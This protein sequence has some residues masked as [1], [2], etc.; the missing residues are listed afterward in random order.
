MPNPGGF[1]N[2]MKSILVLG[3]AGYIGSV[4]INDLL[5]KKYKVT[6]IDNFMYEQSSLNHLLFDKNLNVENKDVRNIKNIKDFVKS[7]DCIFP[8]AAFVGAP[9][10]KK[11]PLG[12]ELINLKSIQDLLKILSKD[13]Y[14][15]M[16]TTN[17]AYGSGNSK[18]YCDEKS[19]LKPISKYA[20]DKVEVEKNI[21]NRRNSISLRLATVFGMSPRMRLDL[22]INDFVYKA[23]NDKYIVLFESHFKRNYIHVMDVSKAFL[24]CMKNFNKMKGQIYNVGLS[25]AN[26]SK[27]EICNLIK[28]YLPEFVILQ[29]NIKKDE[30]QRNYIVSNKKIENTGYKADY[31]IKDGI[32][33]LIKAFKYF[34]KKGYSNI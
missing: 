24:H 16:P 1:N 18:N 21:M 33:E 9:L 26:L 2:Y 10:C 3:G 34:K 32:I 8:L 29:E 13:Q 31:S 28:K 7:S 12:A 30:D 17:S 23:V 4:F 22:L 5:K 27:L 19:E 6:V 14:L 15:I 11:D 20:K 25:N